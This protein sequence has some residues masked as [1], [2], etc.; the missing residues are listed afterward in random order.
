MTDS[1]CDAS[2]PALSL[3]DFTYPGL[4]DTPLKDKGWLVLAR[5]ESRFSSSRDVILLVTST[6]GSLSSC[7][8]AKRPRWRDW[9]LSSHIVKRPFHKSQAHLNYQFSH[10]RVSP[11]VTGSS[12]GLPRPQ[13][14]V[15]SLKFF[16]SHGLI[17]TT[18]FLGLVWFVHLFHTERPSEGSACWLVLC[19]SRSWVAGTVGDLDVRIPSAVGSSDGIPGV[20]SPGSV[21]LIGPTHGSRLV[22]SVLWLA[23]GKGSMFEVE[24]LI[25]FDSALVVR[26]IRFVL[27]R[28]FVCG[29]RV[30]HLPPRWQREDNLLQCNSGLIY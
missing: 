1:S 6:H 9:R 11:W 25:Q 26:S 16:M 10:W 15:F 7:F 27:F 22:G 19:V 28:L 4:I 20:G 30:L 5:G 24:S 2:Q 21:S 14:P 29:G 12:V 23:Q 17:S 3:P 8:V 13:L 18:G